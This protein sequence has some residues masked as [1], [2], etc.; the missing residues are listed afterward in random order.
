MN[1]QVISF[2]VKENNDVELLSQYLAN[3]S[4]LTLFLI[5]SGEQFLRD[6]TVL[7]LA[8]WNRIFSEIKSK[9]LTAGDKIRANILEITLEYIE[10][11]VSDLKNEDE[12]EDEQFNETEL[13]SLTQRFEIVGRLCSFN[14]KPAI[15]K[16]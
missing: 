4:E 7:L 16:L 13:N 3:L 14:L 12:E 9:E 11:N 1:F 10:Q 8:G 2:G 6:I 5:K 15:Q